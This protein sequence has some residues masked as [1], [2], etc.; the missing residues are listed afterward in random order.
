MTYEERCSHLLADASIAV[1][2]LL[3]AERTDM[4]MVPLVPR[5]LG[6]SE[7]AARIA[8]RGLRPVGIVGISGTEPRS[9]FE[10]PL[11]LHVVNVLASAFLEYLR[12]LLGESLQKQSK[13]LE[14]SELARLFS[15][16]DARSN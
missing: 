2:V 14:I 11:D 3:N 13:A 10:E 6:D 4:E 7:V 15:L 8:G 1:A 9:A 12:V 5:P 16:P